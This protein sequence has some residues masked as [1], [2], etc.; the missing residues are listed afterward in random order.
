MCCVS[1]Y[2]LPTPLQVYSLPS[3]RQKSLRLTF[4]GTK[5]EQD[6]FADY[7]IFAI[8]TMQGIEYHLQ[9]QIL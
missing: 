9:S 4:E 7:H 2:L 3:F 8:F 5:R 6:D 1:T